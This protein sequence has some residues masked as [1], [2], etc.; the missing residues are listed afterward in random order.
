MVILGINEALLR[1]DKL[2]KEPQN[3]NCIWEV[4]PRASRW[5]A[6]ALFMGGGPHL[7]IYNNMGG[8]FQ[9]GFHCRINWEGDWQVIWHLPEYRLLEVG[10]GFESFPLTRTQLH[11]SILQVAEHG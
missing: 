9:F 5:P 3:L 8:Y 11:H 2:R 1:N 4:Y 10:S 6:M 7:N